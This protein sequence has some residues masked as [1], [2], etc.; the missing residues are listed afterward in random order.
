MQ[1][2]E[3]KIHR[4]HSVQKYGG[5]Y[6]PKLEPFCT[7]FSHQTRDTDWNYPLI[8]DLLVPDVSK[9]LLFSVKEEPLNF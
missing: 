5:W 3:D 7:W 6:F 1:V 2:M 4:P 9:Q 8:F